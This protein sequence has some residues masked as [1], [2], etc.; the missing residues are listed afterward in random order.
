[1]CQ[2]IL[3]HPLTFAAKNCLIHQ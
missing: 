2:F 1:M 3:N